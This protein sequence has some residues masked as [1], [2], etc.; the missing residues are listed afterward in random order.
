MVETIVIPIGETMP[1]KNITRLEPDLVDA[2][3]TMEVE[4]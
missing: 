4:I 2:T 1:L 3:V